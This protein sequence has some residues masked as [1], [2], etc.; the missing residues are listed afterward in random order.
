MSIEFKPHGGHK[1]AGSNAFT[2]P[3]FPS[4]NGGVLQKHHTSNNSI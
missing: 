2:P 4:V 3:F 1:A